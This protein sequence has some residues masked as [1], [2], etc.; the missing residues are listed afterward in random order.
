MGHFLLFASQPHCTHWIK[1]WWIKRW[2]TKSLLLVGI[3]AMLMS[4]TLA[5]ADWTSQLPAISSDEG[6]LDQQQ[7]QQV[8]EWALRQLNAEAPLITDPWLQQSLETLVW[9][10][11]AV[12]R[13]DAPLALVLINDPQI[14]AFAVPAGL[15]GLN[16]GLINKARSLDEVASVIAHEI[17]HVS[18]RHY[19]HRHDQRT[20]QLLLQAGGILAGLAAAKS[21]EGNA[22]AAVLMGTQAV[23][24][25]RAAT[26]SRSQEQEADRIGMQIMAQAGYDVNAMPRF[27]ATLDQQ[28]PVKANAFIPSFIMSH[29]LTADRLSEARQRASRYPK[30]KLTAT[31][32]NR[33]ALFDQLQWR[34][35]YVGRLT[36]K[37]ELTQA[38]KTSQGAK[39][40]LIALLIDE[41]QYT[42]ATRLLQ[43]FRQDIEQY[44][45]PLA[46]IMAATLQDRQGNTAQ[47]I[48][49]L[50]TLANLLPERRDI[51]LYLADMYLN[52]AT[53]D[54]AASNASQV[55]ALLQPLSRQYPKDL[56]IWQRLQQASQTLAKTSQGDSKTLHQINVLRYRA[57]HEFW[58]NDLTDAVTSLAQA[59]QLAKQLP[60]NTA[61]LAL[62]NQQLAE[63]Q[64]AH[65]FKPS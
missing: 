6:L 37:A 24:A 60:K 9:Q 59:K 8:G 40:A 36:N 29:P 19:Q 26:F 56:A 17:A 15:I 25:N 38:A 31:Q 54:T 57:Y 46:V 41:R 47:A 7:N 12:A 61:L 27:F 22:T 30:P 50:T 55:I 45:N 3:N 43:D 58:H 52:Q 62:I 51:K 32:S 4:P 1:R 44:R 28:N 42:D 16:I 23:S 35:R 63:V 48:T 5:S 49:Q 65:Q 33:N 14:N 10:I 13:Q 39:L 34:A 18:Q 20:Q 11:N 21:G 2:L 64:Q 53:H